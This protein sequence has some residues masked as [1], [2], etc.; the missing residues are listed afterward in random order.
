MALPVE[1]RQRFWH[2]FTM[3]GLI[4][5]KIVGVRVI[6]DTD[7]ICLQIIDDYDF[8]ECLNHLESEGISVEY[9]SMEWI[10]ISGM[11]FRILYY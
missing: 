5:L 2:K 6:I 3:H 11:I 9:I 7:F 1:S 10:K 4:L 8:I